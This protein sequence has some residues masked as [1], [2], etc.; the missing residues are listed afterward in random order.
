MLQCV[1]VWLMLITLSRLERSLVP[2][3]WR[4][5]ITLMLMHALPHAHV[6]NTLEHTA[7]ERKTAWSW[8]EERGARRKREDTKRQ[9]TKTEDRMR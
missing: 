7:K 5:L 2:H 4:M 8:K 1:A 6:A 9:D 3:E